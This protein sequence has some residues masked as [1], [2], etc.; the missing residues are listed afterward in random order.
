MIFMTRI[1]QL[2]NFE[3]LEIVLILFFKDIM[4]DFLL[5]QCKIDAN[6]RSCLR[7][8]CSSISEKDK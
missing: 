2:Y 4:K 6:S 7:K 8:F 3:I 1:L 5:R